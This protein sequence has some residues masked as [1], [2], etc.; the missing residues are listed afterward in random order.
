[1]LSK[2]FGDNNQR[3]RITINFYMV[4]PLDLVDVDEECGDVYDKCGIVYVGLE[5]S[6]HIHVLS[7]FLWNAHK[8]HREAS[9]ICVYPRATSSYI[10]L[11]LKNK[12]HHHHATLPSL[13][14]QK[15]ILFSSITASISPRFQQHTA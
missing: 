15:E 3:C 8:T 7:I 6:K 14:F 12:N 5:T 2:T 1:M 9:Y 13:P 4:L 10:V 11:V